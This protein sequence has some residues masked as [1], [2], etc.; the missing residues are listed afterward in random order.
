MV[1]DLLRAELHEPIQEIGAEI[2][3]QYHYTI[4]DTRHIRLIANGACQGPII[5][6][7]RSNPSV[8]PAGEFG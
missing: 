8:C 6:S 2:A 5:P 3:A 4:S 1:I 7:M